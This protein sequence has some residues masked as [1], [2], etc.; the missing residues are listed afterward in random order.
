MMNV[1]KFLL[2][3]QESFLSL[4]D[5]L[6]LPNVGGL[7]ECS[8][9]EGGGVWGATRG[10]S[11][12]AGSVP[13]VLWGLYS[14]CGAAL[15]WAEDSG[16][17]GSAAAK[18]SIPAGEGSIGIWWMGRGLKMGR[19]RMGSGKKSVPERVSGTGPM[20]GVSVRKGGF[21][22]GICY[23]ARHFPIPLLSQK[24]LISP[25]LL[26][27]RHYRWDCALPSTISE[28]GREARVSHWGE[29]LR[30]HLPANHQT[31]N[32]LGT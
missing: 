14:Y 28:L 5:C 19:R 22:T 7:R 9:G 4:S 29:K 16:W 27:F 12:P 13:L 24:L 10:A 11:Q 2:V 18:C 20:G 1:V 15:G 17:L 8:G 6:W 3:H 21:I 31:W 23:R 26:F 30:L 32:P 25:S